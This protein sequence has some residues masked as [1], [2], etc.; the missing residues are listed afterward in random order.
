ML[1]TIFL[2]E[3]EPNIFQALKT[4]GIDTKIFESKLAN[5]FNRVYNNYVGYYIFKQNE[6]I[7]KLIVLPKT[8]S[9]TS[10]TKEKDFVSYLLHYYRIN[11]IY[12]FDKKKKISD[13][14]LSLAFK[15]NNE[16]NS[17]EPLEQFEFYKY[18]SI[19]NEIEIFF[20]KHKNYKRVLVDYSSQSIKYKLNLAKNIKEIDKTKIHQTQVKDMMFSMVA[21]IVYKALKIFVVKKVNHIDEK[22]HDELLQLTNKLNNFILKKYRVDRSYK[23]SLSKFNSSKVEKYF[24]LKNELKELYINVKSLFGFEQM[25]QESM[26]SVE[27]RYD[28]NTSS[29]FINPIA[30]YEWYVYDILQKYAKENNKL[31]LF[32][33]DKE[34]STKTNY[35]LCSKKI[36]SITKSSNPDYILIDN[37]EKIKIVI[38]AKWKNITQLSD[39]SSSD[40]LKLKFDSKILEST[41]YSIISY[42]AYPNLYSSNDILNVQIDDSIYFNFG[43][44]QIDMNFEENNS[45]DFTYDYTEIK[46]KIKKSSQIV[47]LKREGDLVST[48]IDNQRTEIVTKLLRED[49]LNNKEIFFNELDNILLSSSDRLNEGIEE[50]ISENIKHLLDEYGDILERD[51]KKF[52]KS[53]SSIYNYYKKKNYEHFDYSMPGSG[54]WKLIELELNTSF[55]WFIRV[56]SHVC[57]DTSAWKN[58]SNPKRSIVQDLD[59]RKTV[60]L[61]QY[62]YNDKKTLQGLMLGG[63][64]LLLNDVS[65]LD[66]FRDI[67]NIDFSYLK[68]ELPIFLSKVINLRNEHAHIKAMKLEKYEILDSLLFS[69]LLDET[70]AICKLLDFKRVVVERIKK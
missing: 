51:S 35:S 2:K 23:L 17:H 26:L 44:L 19:L 39:I 22:Y 33:K 1:K 14:L 58:I 55:S 27:N 6:I 70:S 54:L 42:F 37:E 52:L 31:I 10:K 18:Q 61:N 15:N 62:E 29:F 21:T 65:T 30:F 47:K 60:K 32:D 12:K 56:Q 24:T 34:N 66:D 50:Y 57:D 53:S 4:Q 36:N 38:D 63:I 45:I 67:N 9:E 46:E 41:E 7:Y 16:K 49:N 11:S 13:S 20:K 48:E 43:A 69:K 64:N 5:L 3:N 25:Y 59:N 68:N 8:I 40:Y 28:L